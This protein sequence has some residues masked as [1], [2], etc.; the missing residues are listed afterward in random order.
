MLTIKIFGKD[1]KCRYRIFILLLVIYLV[2]YLVMRLIGGSL[3]LLI[4]C[5]SLVV[6][7]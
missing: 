3:Q 4:I 7:I 1:E 6:E 2:I 5:F